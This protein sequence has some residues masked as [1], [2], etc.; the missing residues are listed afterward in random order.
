MKLRFITENHSLKLMKDTSGSIRKLLQQ[1]SK[2]KLLR[3][4]VNIS[5]QGGNH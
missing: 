3:V 4:N 5:R 1:N 2:Y